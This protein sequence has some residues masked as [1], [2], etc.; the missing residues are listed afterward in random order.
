MAVTPKS[1]IMVATRDVDL[2]GADQRP[3]R[4]GHVVAE[5]RRPEDVAAEEDQLAGDRVDLRMRGH[6][7]SQRPVEVVDP[8]PA[9]IGRQGVR[10]PGLHQGQRGAAVTDDVGVGRTVDRLAA[11]PWAGRVPTL[12][13]SARVRTQR[14]R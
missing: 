13:A 3:D 4:V 10:E 11:G 2:L 5:E 1:W 7:R 14:L 6:R 8:G 12:A 9:Q